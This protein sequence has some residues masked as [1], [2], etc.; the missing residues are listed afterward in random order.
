M[1]E[2]VRGSFRVLDS[3]A[4]SFIT[5]NYIERGSEYWVRIFTTEV[6]Q[7]DRV[8]GMARDDIFY[9]L[10]RND[11]RIPVATYLVRM[12]QLPAHVEK[13]QTNIFAEGAKRLRSAWVLGMFLLSSLKNCR[14]AR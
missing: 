6:G 4:P 10:A 14:E 12:T 8:D 2:A 9:A 3:P 1:L 11:I 7:R 13:P 5:N